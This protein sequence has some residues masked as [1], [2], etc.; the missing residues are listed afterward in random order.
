[1]LLRTFVGH[2]DMVHSV[3]FSPDG[4][5]V[6]SGSA[7]KTIK[8][9]DVATGDLLLNFE[10]HSDAVLSVAF[11]PDG[12][13]ALSGRQRLGRHRQALGRRQGKPLRTLEGHSSYVNVVAFLPDGRTVISGSDD[14]TLKLW[15]L[16]TGK[17]KWVG[18]PQLSA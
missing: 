17:P 18:F 7:D 6:L 8:L 16:A 14:K 4:R 2:T 3:A 13:T 12:H 11:S 15:D 1:M 10:G 9:W 5:T